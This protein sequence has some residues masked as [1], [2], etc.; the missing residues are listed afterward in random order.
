MT[1]LVQAPASGITD[2]P[3]IFVADTLRGGS[4]REDLAKVTRAGWMF[5]IDR[6]RI[7]LMTTHSKEA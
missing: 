3:E 1:V 4:R 2:T 5:C 7:V 6:L